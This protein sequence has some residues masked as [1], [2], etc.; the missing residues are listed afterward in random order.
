MKIYFF[1]AILFTVSFLTAQDN[2]L[3]SNDSIKDNRYFEDQLYV[4]LSYI[5]MDKLPDTISSNGFSNSLVFGF[6]KDIP[7]NER[8]NLALGVGLGYGRHTY[9]QNLKISMVGNSTQ[10]DV[11]DKFKSN[12]FSMHAIELPIEFRWRT[13]TTERYKFYRIYFGGKVSYAFVTNSKFRGI[14]NTIKVNGIKEMNKLQ[15][16][17]S[18]SMGYGTLNVNVYY[19]LSDLFSDAKLLGTTPITMRDFRVGLVFYIL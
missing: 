16:G 13:S 8:R 10:F 17:L 14:K 6:I 4:G 9:Y 12:K 15:Y 5:L 19:G 11:A 1:I 7:L 18:L 2:T 3:K